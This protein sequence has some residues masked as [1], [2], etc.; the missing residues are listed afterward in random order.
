MAPFLF[1]VRFTLPI[2]DLG[3]LLYFRKVNFMKLKHW[4]ATY[5]TAVETQIQAD[6]NEFLKENDIDY[7]VGN[8]YW[9]PEKMFNIY[10]IDVTYNW[11]LIMQSVESKINELRLSKNK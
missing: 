5:E 9:I 4:K 1:F 7:R 3:R 6:L 2:V 11:H 10:T 8:R